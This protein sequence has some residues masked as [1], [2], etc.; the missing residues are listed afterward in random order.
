MN[1]P[2]PARFLL[3]CGLASVALH[4]LVFAARLAEERPP[5]KAQQHR[6]AAVLLLPPLTPIPPLAPGDGTVAHTAAVAEPE[7]GPPEVVTVPDAPT[8][9]THAGVV[10]EGDYVPR[11][12]LSVA[13]MPLQPVMLS[14]PNF[15][16]PKAQYQ[17]VLALYI[18]DQGIVQRI[19]V[20]EG[21]LPPE[22]EAQ[23]RA[24][25]TSIR[26]APGELDGAAVRSRVYVEVV[27]ERPEPEPSVARGLG[28]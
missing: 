5:V 28:R 23:A 11:P 1:G 3:F 20:T 14:W 8:T 7:P 25:F 2:V 15:D 13:P 26:F 27:F 17:G 18:D 19:R 9:V 4:A 10:G 12:L 16:G 24:A 22:L 6:S 21:D